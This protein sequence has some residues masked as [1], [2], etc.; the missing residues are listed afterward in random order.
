MDSQSLYI[1]EQRKQKSPPLQQ[2]H[3]KKSIMD[4]NCVPAVLSSQSQVGIWSRQTLL[5]S[6]D[7]NCTTA[8]IHIHFEP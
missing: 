2:N 4:K 3:H 8:T 1:I 7:K 5:Q 6:H